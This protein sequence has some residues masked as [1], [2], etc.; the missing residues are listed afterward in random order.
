MVLFVHLERGILTFEKSGHIH[1]AKEEHCFFQQQLA[2]SKRKGSFARD[3]RP[4]HLESLFSQT[5]LWSL[6]GKEQENFQ[7]KKKKK[8]KKKN[9][10][11]VSFFQLRDGS[12]N[13]YWQSDGPQPHAVNI[14]FPKTVQICRIDIYADVKVDESYTPS[15]ISVR[16]GT[17]LHD[18]REVKNKTK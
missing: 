8:K 13:T 4:W 16:A 9:Q 15:V 17:F 1:A 10:F 11:F 7:K 2:E 6:S 18:L 14:Q 12:V 5:R 3:R